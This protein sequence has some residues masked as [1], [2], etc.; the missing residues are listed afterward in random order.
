MSEFVI[1]ERT[2]GKASGT[3][4]EGMIEMSV[5]LPVGYEPVRYGV[6]QRGDAYLYGTWVVTCRAMMRRAY[7]VVR[8]MKERR[9]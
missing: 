2:E 6:P 3:T 4:F 1:V 9:I 5:E 7:L 8:K